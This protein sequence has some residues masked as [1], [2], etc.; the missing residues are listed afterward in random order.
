MTVS[1]A[2]HNVFIFFGVCI[3]AGPVQ[4]FYTAV[5]NYVWY[6]FLNAISTLEGKVWTVVVAILTEKLWSEKKNLTA[7]FPF[8]VNRL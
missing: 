8:S 2:M 4:L 7:K 1:R 6:R 3:I 5:S